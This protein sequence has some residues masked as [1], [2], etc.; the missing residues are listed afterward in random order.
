MPLF[1]ISSDIP[2]AVSLFCEFVHQHKYRFPDNYGRRS[3]R[4]YNTL[5]SY[6]NINTSTKLSL[7]V[8]I[9]FSYDTMHPLRNA[10]MLI[11]SI[12]WI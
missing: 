10:E 4:N 8:G 3:G 9:W 7:I 6:D 5:H 2:K 1:A 12:K 11:A